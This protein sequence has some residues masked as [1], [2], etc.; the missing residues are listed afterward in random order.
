MIVSFNLGSN[1]ACDKI[2]QKVQELVNYSIKNG[3]DLSNSLVVME[4]KHPV[5]DTSH[6]PKLEHKNN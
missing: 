4:I 1:L 6:I 3:I 2:C 5:E